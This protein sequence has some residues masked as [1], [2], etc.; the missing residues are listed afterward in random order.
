MQL[1][2]TIRSQLTGIDSVFVDGRDRSTIMD[3]MKTRIERRDAVAERHAAIQVS[4]L[5]ASVGCS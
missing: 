4:L 2:L 1:G 5:M 3:D